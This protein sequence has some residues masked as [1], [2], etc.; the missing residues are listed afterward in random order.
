MPTTP[1]GL[2]ELRSDNCAGVAPQVMAAITA[3]NEGTALAYGGDHWSEEL[4]EV[5]AEAFGVPDAQVFPVV[6]G[7]AANSLA[8][9]AMVPPW[10]SV[11]CH[12]T[13][14]IYVNEC[15]ATS[16][17]G[18]GAVMR[19]L[20]GDDFKLDP[21]VVAD[22]L[23]ATNWGDP[24]HSQPSV[25]SFTC[26][27]DFGTV[28][29]A[30]ELKAVVDVAAERGLRAHLDGARLANA[31]AS[32]HCSPTAITRDVGLHAFSL[33]AIKNGVMSTDAIVSLDPAVSEQLLYRTKR[34]GH[35][36]S[37]MRFQ[38]AQL[39]A[40]L[41]DGLWVKLAKQANAAMVELARGVKALGLELVTEPQANIA[42][43]R[44]DEIAW[45]AWAAAGVQFYDIDTELIRLVTSWQTTPDDVTEALTRLERV[46]TTR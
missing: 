28:Y 5:V 32:L 25:V 13:S 18:G 19:A 27:T 23:A 4:H 15:G 16:L 36:A 24:H 42:F 46:L 33:G 41:T 14:H 29:T 21:Q 2:I 20:P 12:Q 34:A 31:I 45:R 17:F 10:G 3:A 11:L 30:D 8:L 9:S 35:V 44:I 26:P 1:A 7:T 38:S 37:K 6:S 40:Y 39:I 22:A 43:V